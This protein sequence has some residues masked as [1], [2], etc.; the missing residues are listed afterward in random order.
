[1]QL[2]ISTDE[3]PVTQ[4]Q[5]AALRKCIQSKM[6]LFSKKGTKSKLGASVVKFVIIASSVLTPILIGWKGG[7]DKSVEHLVNLALISS[8]I[9]TGATAL[10][11]FF[12][13]KDLWTQYKAARNELESNLAELDYLYSSRSELR[14]RA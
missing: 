11:N 5:I 14:L 2:N 4:E 13:Y 1:M 8:A 3:R 6:D 12:D 10:Y 7:D 9:G